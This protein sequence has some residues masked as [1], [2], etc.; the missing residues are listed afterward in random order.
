MTRYRNQLTEYYE[1]VVHV[2]RV[3]VRLNDYDLVM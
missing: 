3:D 2:S 1:L